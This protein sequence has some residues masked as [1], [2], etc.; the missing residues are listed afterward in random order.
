MTAPEWK[1]IAERLNAHLAKRRLSSNDVANKAG[2]DRKT[3]DRL[4]GGQAVRLTT[5]Q[6]I[7]Q[8]LKIDL[9]AQPAVIEPDISPLA[10]G[11]YRKQSVIDYTG[12]YTAYRRSFDTPGFVIASAM[13]VSWDESVPALRFSEDQ[14]NRNQRGKSYQYHF[15][16]D[17]LIPPNLG[18]MHFMVRSDDGRVR[19]IS[20]S[21]P[22]EEYD[23]LLIKGFLM[24]LNEIRDI[25]YYPVTS[26]VFLAKDRGG[27]ST[28]TGVIGDDDERYAWAAD[29]LADIEK[30]Y[31]PFRA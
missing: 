31:L 18:V 21:M 4:R 29:I 27:E 28:A 30:K 15:G 23:T 1:G 14:L 24:T 10:Y 7:E 19:L 20:T 17:V 16:G 9:A 8:A 22:R 13:Q 11:G 25:G 2:V 3:V 5:L 26:P 6:W 12:T